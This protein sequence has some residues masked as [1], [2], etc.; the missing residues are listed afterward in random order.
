MSPE[1]KGHDV[2]SSAKEKLFWSLAEELMA[3]DKRIVESTIMKGRCL[4]V[5]KEFL[6]LPDFKGSGLVV[7]LPAERVQGLILSGKGRPFAP[8]GRVFKEWVS[9]PEADR[10]LWRK[11]L[12]EGLE[13][14]LSA[15]SQR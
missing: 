12:R 15:S 5:G 2:S 9:V 7:K 4:R 6:A 13:H 3:T 8:A 14:A 11:L 10:R 1:S